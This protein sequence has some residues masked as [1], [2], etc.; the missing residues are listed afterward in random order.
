MRNYS[1]VFHTSLDSLKSLPMAQLISELED[2][3][4][5]LIEEKRQHEKRMEK[6]RAKAKGH[7]RSRPRRRR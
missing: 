6:E 3:S 7:G 4:E 1:R 5:D 2:A